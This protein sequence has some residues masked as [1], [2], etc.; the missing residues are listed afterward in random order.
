ME[1]K[2]LLRWL[3]FQRPKSLVAK[4]QN[5]ET[6]I[7]N[8]IIE[9]GPISRTFLEFGF[10]PHE[11]NCC[12]LTNTCEGILIDGN[13][14][15]VRKARGLLPANVRCY[16]RFLDLEAMRWIQDLWAGKKL[17]VLSVDVDGNDYW[18]LKE[19]IPMRPDVVICEYNASLGQRKITVPYKKEFRRMLEHPS[20]WYHG[21]S[22][23]A[24]ETL[25]ASHG[26][27]LVAVDSGGT[28]AFFIPAEK[29]PDKKL[30]KSGEVYLENKFRNQLSGTT[31]E[32]QW[33]M[34]RTCPWVEVA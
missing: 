14:A 9:W 32:E 25:A 6:E 3:P 8:E 28:N 29:C 2:T 21:A 5:N 23:P 19:L 27:S 33:Q 7:L 12:G 15:N 20:G 34:I 1:I 24:L 22:L 31:A 30:R 26:Y 18:F 13:P 16:A 4:S 17:G 10:H 11:F